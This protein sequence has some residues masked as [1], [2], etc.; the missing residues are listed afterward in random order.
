M[1]TKFLAIYMNT[2]QV[3]SKKKKPKWVGNTVAVM[4]FVSVLALLAKIG[5]EA[6]AETLMKTT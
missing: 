4:F 1:R 3:V 5:G 6:L 2:V